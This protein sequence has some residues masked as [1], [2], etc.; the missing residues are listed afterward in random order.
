MKT[1]IQKL[2]LLVFATVGL[3]TCPA[4]FGQIDYSE[5]FSSGARDWVGNFETTDI[6]TC[7]GTSAIRARVSNT[8]AT[9]LPAIAQSPAV[10]I[11]NGEEITLLYSYRLLQYDAVLP[12]VPVGLLDFGNI[13]L[14]YAASPAGPWFELD[15]ISMLN[16]TA[17]AD[18][19]ER[20]ITF[21][22]PR[23]EQIFLRFRA[24]I[25]LAPG[26]DYLVYI[27]EIS[28]LQPTLAI[29][30]NMLDDNAVV[31]PNPISGYVNLDYYGYINDVV[32]FN[33]QGQEVVARNIDDDYRRLDFSGFADGQ[34]IMH[35]VSD[36]GIK[37]VNVLKK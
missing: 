8:S 14:D 11:S 24:D 29:R 13:A 6:A 12:A 7:N 23:D 3:L 15:N 18:C 16:Y 32:I 1:V 26:L 4:A 35:I 37:T 9:R 25:G 28:I 19:T 34:Y 31:Y 27:D 33:M 5:D 21:T 17:S 20:I 30:G 2:C 36:T 10:G 22:P